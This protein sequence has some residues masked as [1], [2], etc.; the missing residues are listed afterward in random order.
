MTPFLSS[1]RWLAQGGGPADPASPSTSGE[2]VDAAARSLR[3]QLVY[4]SFGP[5][6]NDVF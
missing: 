6:P 4:I 1:C 3:E 5:K 2:E